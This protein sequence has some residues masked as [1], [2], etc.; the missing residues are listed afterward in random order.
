M[1]LHTFCVSSDYNE[2]SVCVA[3]LLGLVQGLQL[4]TVRTR[5]G[6][7]FCLPDGVTAGQ[8]ELVVRKF[9]ADN[10]QFLH[11]A[12]SGVFA[13]ALALAFPCQPPN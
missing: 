8:A 6:K 2:K 7:P 4:G 5:E 9:A 12:A 10:P 3:Y 11:L 1:Q 13:A